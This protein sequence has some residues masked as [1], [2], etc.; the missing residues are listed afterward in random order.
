MNGKQHVII[1]GAQSS[2]LRVTSG[3]PQ[4][5]VIGPLL[6]L[7][8]INDITSNIQSEIQLFADDLHPVPY[9]NR[10]Y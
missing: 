10:F 4:G 8:Y 1:D 6:F 7:M 5:T 2:W 3:V 9:N